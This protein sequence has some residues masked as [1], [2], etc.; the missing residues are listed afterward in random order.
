MACIYSSS[1]SSI[2]AKLNF[3]PLS[4]HKPR[5]V[6]SLGGAVAEPKAVN[7]TKPLLLNAARWQRSRETPGVAYETSREVILF[8][9][10]LTSLS[11]MN[12]PFDIV[13]GKGPIIFDPI[14]TAGNVEKVREFTPDESVPGSAQEELREKASDHDG[15]LKAVKIESVDVLVAAKKCTSSE[16]DSGSCLGKSSGF[17]RGASM[18]RGV[19]RHH[20]H[21]RWQ[22]I[23]GRVAGNKDLYLGTFSTE[24]EAAEAYDIA[25][26]K[27]RGLNA[28]TNFEIN[29][30]DV[31]AILESSTLPIG[32][33]AAKRLKEAQA[34]ESSR[35]C[36]EMISLG[37]TFQ[38]GSGPALLQSY[39]LMQHQ[40]HIP[41]DA[42]TF[43][44]LQ[45]QDHLN[46]NNNNKLHSD[47]APATPASVILLV[48]R[49]YEPERVPAIRS[50]KTREAIL[51]AT[52]QRERMSWSKEA[53]STFGYLET[54]MR[55][56]KF[57]FTETP[58]KRSLESPSAWKS[59]WLLRGYCL[60]TI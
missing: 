3:A 31:K 7:A 40:H 4:N 36:E 24:E 20:Q 43:L 16:N 51:A 14:R 15:G 53:K 29:R 26:I 57:G 38:Y 39:P 56:V 19:T 60:I 1:V 33:G 18:Y 58:F 9:D 59:P 45:N 13:K 27:F 11:G 8:S 10:I 12:I 17:S 2:S 21:G 25:A 5:F 30:Y 22:A 34:I 48:Q 37:S 23:I 47:T 55:Y 32:S 52:T 42:Q 50:R 49:K 6:C 46:Y 35:K 44:S 28:V 41:F 54:K